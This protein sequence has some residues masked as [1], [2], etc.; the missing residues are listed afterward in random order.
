MK[1][2]YVISDISTTGGRER[3]TLEKV[4]AFEKYGITAHIISHKISN[5]E[6]I[7]HYFS[8]KVIDLGINDFNNK[9]LNKLIKRPFRK[10]LFKHKIKHHLKKLSPDI[11]ISLGDA[12]S[13]KLK[14]IYPSCQHITEVHGSY[15]LFFD[16]SKKS[17]K[18][19]RIAK[20]KKFWHNVSQNNHMVILSE[21]DAEKWQ[22]PSISIIP[23]FIE[24]RSLY[25]K[26]K[27]KRFIFAGRLSPEKGLDLL[28]E[29]WRNIQRKGFQIELDIFGE[30]MDLLPIIKQYGLENMISV[31]PFD[32]HIIERYQSYLGCIMPS[33][34]EGFGMVALESI[35]QG[36][37]VIAFNIESGL[38]DI[39]KHNRSGLLA[40]PF[41]TEEMAEHIISLYDNDE[42][43]KSLSD[44]ARKHSMSFTE[45][46]I[47]PKWMALF[48]NLVNQT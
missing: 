24:H 26:D 44:G 10:I 43:A 16:T 15:D 19:T 28:I 7:T 14:N 11:I 41:D 17:R 8:D 34:S 40:A 1:V 32:P 29:T 9:L 35:H 31:H 37:P 23:N 4:K 5:K 6:A 45:E 25:E 2:I 30:G 36:T 22:F 47:L 21:V 33:R 12:Y 46:S 38:R 13:D 3:I 42:L 18:K 39:V 20:V 27:Q 48:E